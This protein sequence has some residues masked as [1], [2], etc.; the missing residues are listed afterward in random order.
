MAI[1]APISQCSFSLISHNKAAYQLEIDFIDKAGSSLSKKQVNFAQD[2][3]PVKERLWDVASINSKCGSHLFEKSDFAPINAAL[4]Y[5]TS[6]ASLDTDPII[7]T[8]DLKD[9]HD[10]YVCTDCLEGAISTEEDAVCEFFRNP[11]LELPNKSTR[12]K[13]HSLF[14]TVH[15]VDFVLREGSLKKGV[16]KK[17]LFSDAEADFFQNRGGKAFCQ[18]AEFFMNAMKLGYVARSSSGDFPLDEYVSCV[19]RAPIDFGPFATSTVLYPPVYGEMYSPTGAFFRTLR[20]VHCV[21]GAV[22]PKSGITT[23]NVAAKV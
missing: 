17:G 20:T 10:L 6:S 7:V 23:V 22:D 4:A 13:I 14:H 18:L 9:T 1:H 3:A 15:P 12:K 11:K 16:L 2:R 19:S 21:D 5:Y 8:L